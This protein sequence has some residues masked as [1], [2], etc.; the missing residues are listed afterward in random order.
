MS[1]LAA[2]LPTTSASRDLC[3]KV[4]P[5]A[6]FQF[7]FPLVLGGR[8]LLLSE[9]PSAPATGTVQDTATAAGLAP[10]FLRFFFAEIFGGYFYYCPLIIICLWEAGAGTGHF[11]SGVCPSFLC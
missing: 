9:G 4:A 5:L 10:G 8:G 7:V 1:E 11:P 2:C 3:P 6:Q